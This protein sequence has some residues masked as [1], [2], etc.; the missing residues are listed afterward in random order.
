MRVKVTKFSVLSQIIGIELTERII[1]EL[2]G[3]KIKIPPRGL[4]RRQRYE[5]NRNKFDK[6]DARVV[7]KLLICSPQRVEDIRKEIADLVN[8]RDTV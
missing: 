2:A 8:I 1:D 7:A 6:L 3:S 4:T 5:L